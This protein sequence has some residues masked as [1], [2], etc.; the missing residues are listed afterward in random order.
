MLLTANYQ[1]HGNQWYCLQLTAFLSVSQGFPVALAVL[2]LRCCVCC[3]SLSTFDKHTKRHGIISKGV[4]SK[5]EQENVAYMTISN[6]WLEK[7]TNKHF[8][9]I[10]ILGRTSLCSQSVFVDSPKILG[11]NLWGSAPCWHDSVIYFLQIFQM[12]ISHSCAS[13]SCLPDPDLDWREAA[14]VWGTFVFFF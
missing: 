6:S 1:K 9:A 12:S 5:S 10:L 4:L 2:I 8:V 11:I 7:Y 13:Q 14:E 3:L